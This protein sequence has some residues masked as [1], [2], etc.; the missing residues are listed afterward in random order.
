MLDVFLSP[1]IVAYTAHDP[2]GPWSGK[3][4][5]YVCPEADPKRGTFCYASKQNPVYS[6]DETLVISYA[7]NANDLA[8]VVNDPSL[9]VPRFIRVPVERI[10]GAGHGT[11]GRI[12]LFGRSVRNPLLKRRLLP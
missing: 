6:A 11:R 12:E 7:A 9:Y 3:T 8:T 4:E 2:W 1:T 10:F 5:V